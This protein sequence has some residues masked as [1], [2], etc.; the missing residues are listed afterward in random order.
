MTWTYNHN[1]DG[2]ALHDPKAKKFKSNGSQADAEQTA[3]ILR[4]GEELIKLRNGYW[5][6]FRT[7]K[8]LA[9]QGTRRACA[10]MI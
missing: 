4:R 9:S 3:K 2:K 7:K 5:E 6:V 10:Y 8:A 1:R